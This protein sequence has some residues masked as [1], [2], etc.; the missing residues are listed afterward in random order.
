MEPVPS[1][2]TNWTTRSCWVLVCLHVCLPVCL[3]LSF[4]LHCLKII[5][6]YYSWHLTWHDILFLL[7]LIGCF[8]SNQPEDVC[9]SSL[10]RNR[11]EIVFPAVRHSPVCILN[12]NTQSSSTGLNPALSPTGGQWHSVEWDA[13]ISCCTHG[14]W[15]G[16]W[17]GLQSGSGRTE[18]NACTYKCKHYSFENK[19]VSD[20]SFTPCLLLYQN[21][22]AVVRPPGHHAEESTAM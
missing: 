15:L 6:Q 16:H 20:P 3:F 10:W 9:C 12:C 22:F 14:G 11:G 17:A 18:G 4:R 5:P 8:R 1:I 19:H 2:D 7:P 21:G 13:L